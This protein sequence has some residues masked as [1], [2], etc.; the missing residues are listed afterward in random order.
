MA[1]PLSDV[2]KPLL[3]AT[4][5]VL[6]AVSCRKE[7]SLPE[8]T[9]EG[10]NIFACK[11]N[12]KAWIANGNPAGQPHLV[13]PLEVEFRQAGKDRFYL[14]IYTNARSN[15]HVQLLLHKGQPGVNTLSDWYGKPDS[16]GFAVYYDASFRHFYSY[17]SNP[18]QVVITRLDTV[19]RIISGTFEFKGQEIL[20]KQT[21]EVTEGRFDIDLKTL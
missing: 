12:G 13:K 16:L 21:V 10:R 11:I 17:G 2:I 15:D 5:M 7:E 4:G 19:N 18:G 20:Q 1:G 9:T 8:P 14:L 6:L 3:L